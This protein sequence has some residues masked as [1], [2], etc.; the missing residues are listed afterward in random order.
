MSSMMSDVHNSLLMPIPYDGPAGGQY[1]DG[2]LKGPDYDYEMGLGGPGHFQE[3]SNYDVLDHP[4]RWRLE[5][6]GCPR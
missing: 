4:F 6:R 1:A 3:D 2:G 5:R